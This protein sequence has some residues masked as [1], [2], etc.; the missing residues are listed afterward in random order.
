MP[1][2]QRLQERKDRSSRNLSP[3]FA[4][5]RHGAGTAGGG[6]NAWAC[7][8]RRPHSDEWEVKATHPHAQTTIPAHNHAKFVTMY[9]RPAPACTRIDRRPS[10]ADILTFP[11]RTP[12]LAR[13][14]NARARKGASLGLW[15]LRPRQHGEGEGEGEEG[16]TKREGETEVD[17][18]TDRDR[19]RER[20]R[21]L[22]ER[23]REGERREMKKQSTVKSW[24]ARAK[25][26]RPR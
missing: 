9:G 17:I 1:A 20:E 14:P 26:G 5:T 12:R 7:G 6:S 10:H 25:G 15:A 24:V 2:T 13:M 4:A 18:D 21:N 8:A 16:E 3:N 22:K 11:S 23:K 19:G